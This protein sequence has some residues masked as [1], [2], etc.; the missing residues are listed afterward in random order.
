MTSLLPPGAC[1]THCHVYGLADTPSGGAF[2]PPDVTAEDVIALHARLGFERAVVVQSSAHGT[3]HSAMLGLLKDGDGRYR[4]VALPWPG[5][6]PADCA[7][8]VDA[9]VCGVRLNF[10]PHL[11]RQ[12]NEDRVGQVI[13]LARSLGWHLELHVAGDDVVER[14]AEIA[15]LDLPV[16]IDHMARVDLAGGLE[17]PAVR[18]LRRLLDTGHVWV[19]VSGVDRLSRV[20]PPYADAVA[21]AALLV[22]C[23]PERTLWGTDFPHVNISGLP[24]D[25]AV[26]VSLIE[27]IAPDQRARERLLVTNPAQFFG[28]E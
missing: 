24:P 10:L 6:T 15:R 8:L 13:G 2:R 9:G 28:F 7:P 11:G 20:G 21:L 19:K 18:A 25:D 12:P 4:G 14:E 5:A 1:D 23:A 27:Q 22:A 3:D 26:L 17:S 16:V